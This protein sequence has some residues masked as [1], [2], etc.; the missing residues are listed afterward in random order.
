MTPALRRLSFT[1][2]VTSSVG[3][4]GAVASFLVLSI[5]GLTSQDAETVRGAYLA[6]NLLGQFIIVPLSLA[7]LLTGLVQSLGTHWGLFRHYWVLVKL[8]LTI[9]ATLLLLLH[10]FTAVAGAA[11]RVSAAA[12]GTFPEVGRLGTQLVSDAGLAVLVLLVTA[13]LSVYKPWGS[14]RYGRRKQQEWSSLLDSG[15]QTAGNSLS[16]RRGCD[17]GSRRRGAPRR[18]GSWEPRSLTLHGHPDP[19]G[20]KVDAVDV[21]GQLERLIN[22]CIGIQRAK[23]I[24]DHEIQRRSA[25]DYATQLDA[26]QGNGAKSVGRGHANVNLERSL[27]A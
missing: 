2:H 7:A 5:A 21:V 17:R 8:T 24:L 20:Q 11:R 23:E 6:M 14:T 25:Q 1:A 15:N 22:V 27:A 4:L 26:C 18:R 13:T 10:Q 3:W 9:G 16:R 19:R 12:P